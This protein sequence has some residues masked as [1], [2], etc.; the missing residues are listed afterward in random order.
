MNRRI[1]NIPEIAE[2]YGREFQ[3]LERIQK[4]LAAEQDTP[5][6][7]VSDY[8]LLLNEYERLLRHIIKITRVGDSN[9]KKLMVANEQINAQKDELSKAY[10]KLETIAR[11][12]SL[13]GLS[14]RRDFLE[15]VSEEVHRFE[16]YN[17]P[18]S[19]VLGDI[20]NFKTI[21]DT[22][23][24]DAG[25]YVLVN[26]A[27]LLKNTIRKQDLAAR[28]GGEEFILMLPG[29]PTEGGRI[30]AEQVC[31]NIQFQNFSYRGSQL[32][33]TMTLG[34]SG[35]KSDEDIETCIKRADQAL[36]FGKKFGKNQVVLYDSDTEAE[37]QSSQTQKEQSK[38]A[39]KI[40]NTI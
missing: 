2:L 7:K 38:D 27:R 16:R 5:E 24:H 8:R 1:S 22:Y 30:V 18:F 19:L 15:K 33:V 20:D 11:T 6:S 21:N 29:S 17:R 4:K 37:A 31:N 34:V 39:E 14:N 13:T 25:D 40:K 35:Y 10:S 32:S 12:D 9:Q 3:L 23:G 36:Y 26:I 28:W